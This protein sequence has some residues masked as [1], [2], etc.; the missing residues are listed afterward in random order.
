MSKRE[1]EEKYEALVKQYPNVYSFAKTCAETL[2]ERERAHVP[3]AIVRPSIILNTWR[4]PFHGWVENV[5]SGACGFIAGVGSGIF[6]TYVFTL[7]LL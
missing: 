2:L 7:T 5:N 3:L 6:Y 1:L 4:E